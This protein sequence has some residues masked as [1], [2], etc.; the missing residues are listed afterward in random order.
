MYHIFFTNHSADR[1]IGYFYVLAIVKS[2]AMK[3]GEHVFFFNHGLSG[4]MP[5]NGIS[6]L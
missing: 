2:V 6:G 1:H 3:T 4:F 5:R